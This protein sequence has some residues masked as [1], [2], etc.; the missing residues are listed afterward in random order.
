M[1]FLLWFLEKMGK[2]YAIVDFYGDVQ[3][4]RYFPFYV[5][6]HFNDSWLSK[7]PNILIHVFPGEPGGW[8]PDGGPDSKISHGHPWSAIGIILKGSYTEVI[9]KDKN[10]TTK[11]LGISFTS[12]KDHHRIIGV[13]PNTVSIF[14]HWFKRKEWTAFG[15]N[16][17]VI[18]DACN[19][20]NGGVCNNQTGDFEFNN[21][22]DSK[23]QDKGWRKY[24]MI[25]VN[26]EFDSVIA[27]RKLAIKR[28]GIPDNKLSF[29]KFN[30]N[31]NDILKKKYEN[32]KLD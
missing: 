25:Q 7:F 30:Y 27:K 19:Q 1:K 13:E 22:I 17:E 24:K 11:A 5:E 6:S 16:C 2:K 12:W 21:A 3:L 8:G 14:C 18:C 10:K 26:A 23:S 32:S 31:R 9:N 29:D 15:Y 20:Y 4:Y 28:M